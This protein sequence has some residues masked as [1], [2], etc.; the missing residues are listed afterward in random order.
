MD[1]NSELSFQNERKGN[2]GSKSIQNGHFSMKTADFLISEFSIRS[3]PRKM[4][5]QKH[6]YIIFITEYFLT[7]KTPYLTGVK[8]S[9]NIR[10]RCSLVYKEL[11]EYSEN[12]LS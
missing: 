2:L 4:T 3:F 1:Q 5:I 7:R 12:V 11:V 8:I 9:V 10:C 6:N